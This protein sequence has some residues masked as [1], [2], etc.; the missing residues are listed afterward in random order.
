MPRECTHECDDRCCPHTCWDSDYDC[1]THL[2]RDN[3]NCTDECRHSHTGGC[4]GHE[5][6][7]CCTHD[8]DD[9]GCNSVIEQHDYLPTLRF[10]G[11]NPPFYGVEL[12][13]EAPSTAVREACAEAVTRDN[14]WFAKHDG[15]LECGFEMVSHP[16]TIE[17]WRAKNLQIFNTLRRS[18]IT[19]YQ[20]TTCGMHVHVSR[21]ELTQLDILKLLLLFH[22]DP[23][24]VLRASRRQSATNLGRWA[25]VEQESTYYYVRKVKGTQDVGRYVAINL[26]PPTTIE[27][28]IFRGTLFAPSFLRNIEFVNAMVQF[29]K[30]TKLD[31]VSSRTLVAW[32][33]RSGKS[34]LGKL[35]TATLLP[36]MQECLVTSDEG[37]ER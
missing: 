2:C 17:Y 12:E 22:R 13:V 16:A 24:F 1:C 30:N 6:E 25:G 11:K 28:R 35:P 26:Q 31:A 8:C 37:E 23:K 15:S 20:T 19:S 27:F 14:F 36:W 29:V 10:Y 33:E 7:D 9:S 3:L 32:L 4:C 5:C 34:V 21:E 18:G